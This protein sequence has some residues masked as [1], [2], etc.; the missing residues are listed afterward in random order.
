MFMHCTQHTTR[1]LHTAQYAAELHSTV[2][3]ANQC[4]WVARVRPSTIRRK[5]ALLRGVEQRERHT[6]IIEM[7]SEDI[8]STR[9]TTLF[10]KFMA[11]AHKFVPVH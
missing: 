2:D 5:P 10:L 7:A 9:E 4:E 6:K 3:S 1:T 11:Q 8:F